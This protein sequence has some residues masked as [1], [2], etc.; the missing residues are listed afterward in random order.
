MEG[1]ADAQGWHWFVECASPAAQHSSASNSAVPSHRATQLGVGLHLR[2]T[3][4][5]GKHMQQLATWTTAVKGA[6]N[7]FTR[8]LHQSHRTQSSSHLR[9]LSAHEKT[10]DGKLAHACGAQP[11]EHSEVAEQ[12]W[13]RAFCA[14][15]SN[16]KPGSNTEH[17][18]RRWQ[19]C[20][21][22]GKT[23]FWNHTD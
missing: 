9:E 6:Q 20:S 1:Q 15:V 12:R 13:K 21:Q 4:S 10:R 2:L 7:K 5:T 3:T 22:E 14:F 17:G 18:G 23:T 8:N 11:A 19:H 16:L